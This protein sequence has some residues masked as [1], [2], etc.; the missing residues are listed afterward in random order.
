MTDTATSSI[1]SCY[2][3]GLRLAIRDLP[4]HIEICRDRPHEPQ[5]RFE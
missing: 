5:D 4:S 3:C 2:Y 1:V